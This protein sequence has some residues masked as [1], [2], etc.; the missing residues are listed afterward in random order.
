MRKTQSTKE[1]KI[2]A[3]SINSNVNF[4]IQRSIENNTRQADEANRNLT[5][6]REVNSA[7]DGAARFSVSETFQFDIAGNQRASLN[8]SNADS[9]LRSAERGYDTNLNILEQLNRT[10]ALTA[11][12]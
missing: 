4:S 10:Y 3:L 5:T 7:S 9:L 2:M 12:P 1:K 6:G 8:V 11:C